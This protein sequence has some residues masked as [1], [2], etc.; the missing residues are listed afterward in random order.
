M[1]KVIEESEDTE[2]EGLVAQVYKNMSANTV[3]KERA[4]LRKDHVGITGNIKDAFSDAN[5]NLDE[6]ALTEFTREATAKDY[7]KVKKKN[8]DE[9]SPVGQTIIGQNISIDA[10]KNIARDRELAPAIKQALVNAIK[11]AADKGDAASGGRDDHATVLQVLQNDTYLQ[12]F[13]ETTTQG[14][15]GSSAS[16]AAP[17]TPPSPSRT[18][19]RATRSVRSGTNRTRRP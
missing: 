13:N 19:Q 16:N 8:L 17:S 1:K 2:T 15:A 18:P 5:G 10:M 3:Q 6:T 11:T 9:L 4:R 14:G 7:A 12:S